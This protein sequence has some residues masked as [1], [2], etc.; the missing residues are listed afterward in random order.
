MFYYVDYQNLKLVKSETEIDTR[1]SDN[2]MLAPY[3]SLKEAQ[4]NLIEHLWL[5]L[6]SYERSI[7]KKI[8]DANNFK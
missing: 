8:Q 7:E 6:D 5:C 1:A 4:T 2:A 3:H